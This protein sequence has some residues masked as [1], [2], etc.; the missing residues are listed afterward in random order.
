MADGADAACQALARVFRGVEQ[1]VLVGAR[2]HICFCCA[3]GRFSRISLCLTL[4]RCTLLQRMVKQI[5]GMNAVGRAEEII[6]RQTRDAPEKKEK[7][8]KLNTLVPFATDSGKHS[9]T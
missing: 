4:H 9:E 1:I 5:C 6:S 7:Q 3:L 2:V 8:I